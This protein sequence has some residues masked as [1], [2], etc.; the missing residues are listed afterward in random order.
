MTHPDVIVAGGGIIGLMTGWALS[1]AG[2]RAVVVDAGLPAATNAA[3]GMLAP[4]FE[5]SLHKSGD[6][7]AA[8]ARASL[9]RWRDIAPLLA[10]RSA[11]ACDYQECGILFVAFDD[12]EAAAFEADHEGGEWL[13]RDD[14]LK[15]EPALSP[16]ARGGRIAK[17]DGQIDPR[18]ARTALERALVADGGALRRGRRVVELYSAGGRVGGVIL[19][20]GERLA[21]PHV[22]VATGARVAGIADLAEGAA[23]PVKGEALAIERVAGSPSRVVRT[24]RA[25]LCPKA[26]GRIVIGA[27]EVKGDWSVIAD[28]ARTDALREGAKAAFPALA[29]AG[30]IERWAG[31]R[32]ATADGAPIIGPAPDGPAGVIFALGHYR[33]GILLAPATADAIVRLVAEGRPDPAIAA[34]SAARFNRLGVS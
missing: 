6:D 9:A 15:L 2:L 7:L 19:D 17:A 28:D 26:D 18:R 4:S 21:A 23:F 30:E 16:K 33:N 20:N 1:R 3:A 32:P 25:Y 5:G 10:D 13:S 14:V 8:F 11:V 29:A 27:T 24:G 12:D 22:I 34:F 31:L